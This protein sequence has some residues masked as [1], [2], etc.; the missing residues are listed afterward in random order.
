MNDEGLVMFV[1]PNYRCVDCRWCLV[2][3][4]V[5][6]LDI[7][8]RGSNFNFCLILLDEIIA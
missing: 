4:S 1:I 2:L 6:H 8:G 3:K 7:H 5:R